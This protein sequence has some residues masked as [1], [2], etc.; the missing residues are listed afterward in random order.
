MRDTLDIADKLAWK[1]LQPAL[2]ANLVEQGT[3]VLTYFQKSASIRLIPYAPVALIGIPPTAFRTPGAETTDDT[4]VARDLLTTAHEVGHYV[5]RRGT[6]NEKP[7][8]R[9]LAERIKDIL[10]QYKRWAE[11]TFADSY[12]G[13]VGGAVTALSSQDLALRYYSKREFFKDDGEHPPANFRPYIYVKVLKEKGNGQMNRIADDLRIR[14][15]HRRGNRITEL[16]SGQIEFENED[17]PELGDGVISLGSEITDTEPVDKIISK[18]LD[19][20]NEVPLDSSDKDSVVD[21]LY[22]NFKA[23]LKLID[24]ETVVP[25]QEL[26]LNPEVPEEDQLKP[27]EEWIKKEKF[28]P[29]NNNEVP[30]AGVIDA[31][32][33]VEITSN[34]EPTEDYWIHL[35]YCAGWS[36][37]IGNHSGG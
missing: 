9:E 30:V 32:S 19:I 2:E 10:P 28:F 3:T 6:F 7:I 21:S 29:G 18:V 4:L 26:K 24:Q 14:W 5:Y 31:G 37:K 25:L 36:T 12:A 23:K 15:G 34:L 1:Y 35:A 13:E 17:Q 33:E 16:V 20:L 11:E 8:Y 22:P 27:W